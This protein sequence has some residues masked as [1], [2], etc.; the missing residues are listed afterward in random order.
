MKPFFSIGVTTYNRPEMLKQTLMS[1]N[2][3]SFSDFEVIVGN[4]Y[5]QEPLSAEL[6]GNMDSRIR[7]INHPQ[8]LGEACNMNTLLNLSRGLYFTWQCDDDLYAPNF[9]D[10]VHSALV[11]YNSPLCVF[12]AASGTE[13]P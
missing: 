11:K 13:V 6:L 8:N 1:I 5:I 12:I 10:D 7:F 3:Q 4:D 2:A 9:L